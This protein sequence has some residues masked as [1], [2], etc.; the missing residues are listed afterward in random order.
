MKHGKGCYKWED[1][2]MYCGDY[3]RDQKHGRGVYR[4]ADGRIYIGDWNQ[5]QQDSLRVYILPNGDIK[6]AQWE[7]GKKGEYIPMEEAEK[8]AYLRERDDALRIEG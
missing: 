7:N 2:R 1:G 4:W 6:K 3:E 8:Q 5:G